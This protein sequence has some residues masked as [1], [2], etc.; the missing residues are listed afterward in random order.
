MGVCKEVYRLASIKQIR[1]S[2]SFCFYSP[3]RHLASCIADQFEKDSIY[4]F[5]VCNLAM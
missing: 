5:I 4:D 2:A 3:N 1:F